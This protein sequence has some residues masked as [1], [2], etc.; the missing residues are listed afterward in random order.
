[1]NPRVFLANQLGVE[2]DLWSTE[3]FRTK[4]LVGMNDNPILNEVSLTWTTW[5]SGKRKS[6]WRPNSSFSSFEGF[7]AM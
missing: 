7:A 5:P 4:L 2:E 3:A 6:S 1:M